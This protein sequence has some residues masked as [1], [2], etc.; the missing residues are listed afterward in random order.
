M[1]K[2]RLFQKLGTR[3]A[4]VA[5]SQTVEDYIIAKHAR[6]ILSLDT[7]TASQAAQFDTEMQALLLPF[8]QDGLLTFSV[9][10]RIIWGKPK[11]GAKWAGFG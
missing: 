4:E 6:S 11:G 1:E 8:A 3:E 5:V 10:G 7:M 2:E 9:I